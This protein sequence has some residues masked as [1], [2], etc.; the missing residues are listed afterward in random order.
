[1]NLRTQISDRLWEAIASAYESGNY[2]HAVLESVHVITEV[3]REKS[4]LDG[5]GNTLVGSALGGDNPRVRLNSLMTETERNIQKGFESILRGL[6]SAIRNPRSHEAAADKVE[7]ADAIIC[8][9]NYLLTVLDASKEVFTPEA[10]MTRVTDPDFVDSNRYSELLVAQIPPSRLGDALIAIFR[11]RRRL[12]LQ[13]RGTF[14]EVLL[15]SASDPQIGSAL[16]VVSEEL[17]VTNDATD[18]KTAFQFLKPELWSRLDE[19]ARR[20]IETKIISGIRNGKLSSD[21]TT[22]EWLA[23]W[24]RDFLK[25]F[26]L[27]EDVA[28]VLWLTLASEDAEKRHFGTEYFFAELPNICTTDRQISRIIA[29]IVRGV[30][31]GDQHMRSRLLRHIDNLPDAWRAKLVDGLAELTD[32]ESPARILSDGTPF[33]KAEDNQFD[34]DI[35]F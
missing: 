14:I 10:F 4:G 20:R 27:R 31:S 13:K 17:M 19:S 35:P 1:M 25:V 23:T 18:I 8:F 22:N 7:Q 21:G 3:L 6:Y 33:L 2:A 15:K 30:K 11:E 9:V 16:A 29:A 28:T 26:T 12:P 34:D 32:K 5:D 24:G